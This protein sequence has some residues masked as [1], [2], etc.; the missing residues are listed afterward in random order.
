MA[1][2]EPMPQKDSAPGED[3]PARRR[4]SVTRLQAT[5]SGAVPVVVMSDLIDRIRLGQ[6]PAWDGVNP[7]RGA[8]SLVLAEMCRLRESRKGRHRS[9]TSFYCSV[10]V[11]FLARRLS[12][13]HH[14]VAD[15]INV[16]RSMGS[17]HFTRLP[18]A[19]GK[20][21]RYL[22]A[23][24]RAGKRVGP[25]PHTSDKGQGVDNHQSVGL[26][27]HTVWAPSTTRL[28]GEGFNP[29]TPLRR[30]AAHGGPARERGTH[31]SRAAGPAAAAS[32][33][34]AEAPPRAA[35]SLGGD[36][37]QL[38]GRDAPGQG[39]P[40]SDGLSARDR[41]LRSAPDP[42]TA[43]RLIAFLGRSVR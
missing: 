7:S 39:D 23:W 10:G 18:I 35:P 29:P 26:Q 24:P 2:T 21:A 15:C 13:E 3:R 19:R 11:R 4:L 14:T 22:L 16:L 32:P 27:N 9:Y 40:S 5:P 6:A 42:E 8:V 1:A 28:R 12:M 36:T 25:Q 30:D 31:R 20:R 37:G 41:I 34:P 33:A 38:P 43:T 17:P